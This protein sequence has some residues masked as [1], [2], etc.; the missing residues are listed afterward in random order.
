MSTETTK[1]KPRPRSV[2]EW[3]EKRKKRYAN[4][5][6]SGGFR[7]LPRRVLDSDAF[8]ELS[9]SAK[10]VLI[11]SLDQLDYWYKKKHKGEFKRNS[12]VGQLRNDGR[13]SLP[14]NLLKERRITSS[15]TIAKTRRELVAAGFWETVE[16]GTLQQSGIFRWSDNW[17]TYNQRSVHDRKRMPAGAKAPGHCLYPNITRYNETRR[18][19]IAAEQDLEPKPGQEDDPLNEEFRFPVQLELF[20]ELAA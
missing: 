10:L 20:P 16:T 9:K 4:D 2:E 12:T 18:A 8:N 7:I 13:F 11:L 5:G 6:G 3:R 15:D 17:V 19:D 14:S 1:P